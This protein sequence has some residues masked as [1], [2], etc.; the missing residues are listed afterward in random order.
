MAS[1]AAD[2][3]SLFRAW[4]YRDQ[5]RSSPREGKL[6]RLAPGAILCVSGNTVEVETRDLVETPE[7]SV[8]RYR[9]RGDDCRPELWVT[10]TPVSMVV[11]CR[12]ECEERITE[13]EVEV[14]SEGSRNSKPR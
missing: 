1:L 7:G 14:W 8:L 5:I 12:D 2:A 3:A 9:C 11:W 6:L 13:D 10:A 4:W